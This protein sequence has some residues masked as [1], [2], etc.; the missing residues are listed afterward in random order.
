MEY[1]DKDVDCHCY[2][3]VIVERLR[4][5]EEAVEQHWVGTESPV[6]TW[7]INP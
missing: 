4:S 1:V 3:I 6:Q 7:D 5:T 2:I